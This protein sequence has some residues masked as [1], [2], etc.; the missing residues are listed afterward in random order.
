[1]QKLTCKENDVCV[2]PGAVVGL[3]QTVIRVIEEETGDVEL[4]VSVTFPV[5][6]CPIEF[7]FEVRLSTSDGT[8]GKCILSSNFF[9]FCMIRFQYF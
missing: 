7:P 9:A 1:M 2:I 6:D 8:A 3:E 4:C 5:I